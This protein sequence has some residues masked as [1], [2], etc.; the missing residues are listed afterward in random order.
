MKLFLCQFCGQTLLFENVKCERCGHQLGYLPDQGLLSAVEPSGANW[1]ALASPDKT[2]RFCA[3]WEREG[4]NWMV[5]SDED[6]IFCIACRHNRTIP[7]I[8]DPANHMRWQKIEAA[9]RRLV[10]TLIN[11]DLPLPTAASN[12]SE[13]LIFDFLANPAEQSKGSKVMTG[14]DN[15]IITLSLVEADDAM[16]EQLRV[17]MGEPY[18]TLL[19]HFRHE[20]GHY[21]WDRLVRDGG[22]IDSCRAVFGDESQ[23]Y[24]EALKR[25]YTNGAPPDWQQEF[26]SAYSTSHPW[27]DFAETFAHYLHI[28]DT[29]E[30]ARAFGVRTKPKVP[31][32]DALG[33]EI[34]FRPYHCRDIHQLIDAWLPLT[35]AMNCINR[36]MGQADLY[37]FVLPPRAIEKLGYV[38][39]LIH[40]A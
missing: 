15:G 20:I 12:D 33:A 16:R 27:E 25:H 28:V 4:C 37:P 13:P 23:D 7:D 31:E 2:Y 19:G 24:E 18:R 5:A 10:Y 38:G 26:V 36:S 35:L 21:Y 32:G 14:H 6:D 22:R 1:T 30:T 17:T 29:L 11:L 3:N 34:D 39:D 8:S 40:A 9:K